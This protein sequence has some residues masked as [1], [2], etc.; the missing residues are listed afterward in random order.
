M[1]LTVLFFAREGWAGACIMTKLQNTS[2]IDLKA[3]AGQKT[4][5]FFV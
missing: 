5:Q 1:A 2:K 4:R 3:G